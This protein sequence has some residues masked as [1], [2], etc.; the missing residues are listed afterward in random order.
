MV[1]V[2]LTHRGTLFSALAYGIEMRHSQYNNPLFAQGLSGLISQFIGDPGQTAQNELFAAKAR[3]ENMTAQ[4]RDAMGV[5][6][7]PGMSP[8]AEMLVQSLRAGNQYSNNAVGVVKGI[9][10]QERG[11]LGGGGG[12]LPD[13]VLKEAQAAIARGANPS[14]VNA[15]LNML[16]KYPGMIPAGP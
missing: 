15:H 14:E 1:V 4:F 11:R 12:A 2:C 3:N 7:T 13:W 5:G 9:N 6:I 8:L 16:K 10:L